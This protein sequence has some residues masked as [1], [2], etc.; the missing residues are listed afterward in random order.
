MI[1]YLDTSALV[2]MIVEEVGADAATGWFEGAGLVASSV[3]TYAESCAALEQNDRRRGTSS[4][5]LSQWLVDLDEYWQ[6]VM[7]VP[8]AEWTAGRLALSH[9]LRGMDAVQLAAAVTLRDRLR[10]GAADSGLAEVV[11]RYL[12]PG[13]ARGGRARRLRHARPPARVAARR[14]WRTGAPRLRSRFPLSRLPY[15]QR[16]MDVQQMV[17]YGVS[18]DV[19]GKQPIV[20]LK[21]VEGNKFLP[22][23]IGHPEA[24]AILI[25]LQ[26]TKLP[27]PMTHDLLTNLIG[28]L[29]RRA[30]AHHRHRA[31]GQHLLRQA[32]PAARTAPRSTSTRGPAT[33]WPSRSAP[34]R[35]SS[36]PTELIVENAIEFEREV[37]D[38]EEIV[39]GFR[40]FLEKVKPEDFKSVEV[41]ADEALYAER[42]LAAEDDE[43]ED[44]EEDEDLDEDD[45][46]LDDEDDDSGRA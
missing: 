30:G 26:G 4:T 5:R 32:H 21:T 22:I 19:I 18:F 25:K 14:H 15:N 42:E 6:D 10:A 24:A 12:R 29:R 28:Q 13:V 27:R 9:H 3:V 41:T 34:R 40:D 17:I 16:A 38:T 23:W 35:R 8:V 46:D 31:Q 33:R 1:L 44:D 43:D 2:K 11:V 7:R 36:P 20:L 45:E 37:D 39:E